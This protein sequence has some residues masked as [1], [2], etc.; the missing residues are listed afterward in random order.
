MKHKLS[1][2]ALKECHVAETQC[3]ET[4]NWEHHVKMIVILQLQIKQTISSYFIHLL[5][6]VHQN[7]WNLFFRYVTVNS[8][9]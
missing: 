6:T 9:N 4:L 5:L 2:L 8:W 1:V 3:Y 7:I